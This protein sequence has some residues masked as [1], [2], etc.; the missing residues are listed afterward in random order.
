MS[1]FSP[2]L[3]IEPGSMTRADI[4][5]MERRGGIIVVECSNPDT[6]RFADPPGHLDMDEHARAAMSLVRWIHAK[7]P[8]FS[9]NNG[10]AIQFYVRALLEGKRPQSVS[11]VKKAKP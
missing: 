3:M 11:A 6:T 5:R 2:V 4:G 7:D 1:A 9:T 10:T 8:Q